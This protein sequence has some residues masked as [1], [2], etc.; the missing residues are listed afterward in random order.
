MY[1]YTH[2]NKY[3]RVDPYTSGITNINRVKLNLYEYVSF[4]NQTLVSCSRMTHLLIESSLVERSS[5]KL[6]SSSTRLYPMDNHLCM[7]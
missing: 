1:I 4:N 3:I 5:N 2:I 6:A 7:Y